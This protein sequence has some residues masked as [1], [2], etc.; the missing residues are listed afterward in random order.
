MS[1]RESEIRMIAESLKALAKEGEP[2]DL[3]KL[4]NFIQQKEKETK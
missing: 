1:F 2:E 3:V 4:F